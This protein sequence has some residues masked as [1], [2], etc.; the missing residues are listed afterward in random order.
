[1]FIR[2]D[3]NEDIFRAISKIFRRIKK[4]TKKH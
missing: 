3:P 4:S 1:M 2:I